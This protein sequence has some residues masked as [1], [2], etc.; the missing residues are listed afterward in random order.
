MK[1]QMIIKHIMKL[2]TIYTFCF[3]C[4]LLNAQHDKELMNKYRF[5]YYED[6]GTITKEYILSEA[7]RIK[8]ELVFSKSTNRLISKTEYRGIVE[9]GLSL[10]FY[11]SGNI[12]LIKNYNYGYPS[13]T[14]VSYYENGVV[15]ALYNWGTIEESEQT[16]KKYGEKAGKRSCFR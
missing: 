10:R 13:G 8:L 6:K 12:R 16:A 1:R 2:L 3:S 14:M 11:E 9:H 4:L 15:K 7:D 5:S